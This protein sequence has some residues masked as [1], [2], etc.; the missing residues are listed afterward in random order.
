MSNDILVFSTQNR[1]HYYDL[2]SGASNLRS[3]QAIY[4]KF[5]EYVDILVQIV[6]AKFKHNKENNNGYTIWRKIKYFV[7][8]VASVI[9][10]Q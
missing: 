6:Y 4:L 7:L 1:T 3:L 5:V 2:F 8:P 10:A 9:Q